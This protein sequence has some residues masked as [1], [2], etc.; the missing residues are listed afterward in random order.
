ML[1][2]IQ[3]QRAQNPKDDTPLPTTFTSIGSGVIVDSKNGY[4]LTN[5]HV[6]NDAQKMSRLRLPMADI[7]MRK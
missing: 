2:E 6:I 4:I 5:A 1:N 3:K 7:T